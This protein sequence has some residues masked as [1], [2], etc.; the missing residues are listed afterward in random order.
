ML[1]KQIHNFYKQLQISK[2]EFIPYVLRL[3]FKNKII[4]FCY[5]NSIYL[6]SQTLLNST[7]EKF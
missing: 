3:K 7:V 1:H 5:Y 2:V 4:Y 6:I